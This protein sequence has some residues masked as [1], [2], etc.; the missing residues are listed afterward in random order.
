[1]LRRIALALVAPLLVTACATEADQADLSTGGRTEVEAIALLRA[2]PDLAVD[3]GSARFEMVFAFDTPDGL[4]ELSAVGGYSGDAMAMEMDL[5]SMLAGL[6]GQQGEELP[7]GFEE[8]MQLVVE[9]ETVYLRMPM[10]DMLTGTSG[11]LSA[12][13]EDLGQSGEALGV[14]GTATSPTQLLETLRG[15]ADDVEEVG[16]D[17]VRG[18]DT[19]RYR[20]TIDLDAVLDAIPEEQRAQM[21]TQLGELGAAGVTSLPLE[22]WVDDDGLPRRMQMELEGVGASMGVPGS[23]T[24]TMEVFDYGEP[25]AVEVPSPSEVTPLVEAMPGLGG[26]LG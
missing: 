22:V 11:W 16:E 5:G 10:L 7:P 13:P 4:M 21:E 9:G 23:A 24:M 8:P 2:A 25:Y 26:A 15:V 20:A 12:T 17:T 19:T 6:A 1:M 3:A 18:V 14:T